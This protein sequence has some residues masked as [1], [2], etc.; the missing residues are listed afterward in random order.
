VRSTLQT[1]PNQGKASCSN[2]SERLRCILIPASCL[3]DLGLIGSNGR[4]TWER[5][6][7]LFYRM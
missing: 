3:L 7:L 2:A 5:A 6:V 1:A 4:R